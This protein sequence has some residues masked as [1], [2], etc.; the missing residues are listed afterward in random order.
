MTRKSERVVDAIG[1]WIVT[2]KWEFRLGWGAFMA[3]LLYRQMSRAWWGD[4]W[5]DYVSV[6][7][8]LILVAVM[9]FV[10][11]RQD[12]LDEFAEL[13]RAAIGRDA[14]IMILTA[15]LG[16]RTRS[17]AKLNRVMRDIDLM[18]VSPLDLPPEA[19]ELRLIMD[20]VRTK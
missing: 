8:T 19:K 10:W 12:V 18:A 2:H 7:F 14:N 15:R 3:L 6:G 9:C 4:H 1:Q 11:W 17:V 5:L 16:V 13:T 20:S